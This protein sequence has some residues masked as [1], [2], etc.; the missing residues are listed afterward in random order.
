MTSTS[1]P[2]FRLSSQATADDVLAKHFR[3]FGDATRLRILDL[4]A[5]GER[6]V[7]ELVDLLDEPQP[8]VSNHLAA[9]RWCGYV[10]TERR[11]KRVIYRLS[12]Q[13]VGD[14]VALV[15]LLAVNGN[16]NGDGRPA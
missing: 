7:G 8:K 2:P 12:D 14:V 9:L 10:A 16:G 1:T 15:R 3:G 4:L 13:R 11:G 5:A 6:S